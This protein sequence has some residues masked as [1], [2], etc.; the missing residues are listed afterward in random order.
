M[1][2]ATAGMPTGGPPAAHTGAGQTMSGD[3]Q[4]PASEMNKLFDA[5]CMGADGKV[6]VYDGPRWWEDPEAHGYK[7]YNGRD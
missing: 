4:Q 7:S 6:R 5:M 3:A 1:K 2:A